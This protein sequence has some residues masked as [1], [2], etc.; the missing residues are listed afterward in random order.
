MVLYRVWVLYQQKLQKFRG[1][2]QG[3]CPLVPKGNIR[4][5][6]IGQLTSGGLWDHRGN[7]LSLTLEYVHTDCTEFLLLAL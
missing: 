6:Y 4:L 3:T 5:K 1:V 2:A 7:L